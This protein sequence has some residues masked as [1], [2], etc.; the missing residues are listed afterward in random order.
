M[1]ISPTAS[2]EV[3]LPAPLNRAAAPN[4]LLGY[5]AAGSPSSSPPLSI[6]LVEPDAAHAQPLLRRLRQHGHHIDAV[7]TGA[8]ALADYH[9]ADLVLL[10][11]ELPD[12]DGLEVCRAIR[13]ISDVPIITVT[14]RADEI[15]RVHGLQA[16][17][18]DCLAKPYGFRELIARIDAVM[19]RARP[20]PVLHRMIDHG[21]LHIDALSREVRL[22]D[23]V[24]TLTRKEFDLLYLLASQPNAVISRR[25]I[26]AQIWQDTWLGSTRTIDTHIS[27]LRNKLGSGSWIIT[28]RGVGFQLGYAP[29]MRLAE[30][31]MADGGR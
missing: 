6:L 10:D 24:I 23:R 31:R 21:P 19:R 16:G 11:T 13:A 20:T 4:P 26:M 15:D 25:Q 30:N 22:H 12:V 9:L 2:A 7:D 18:D 28:V 14:A 29:T 17:S 1:R 3:V 5:S 27:S 8:K